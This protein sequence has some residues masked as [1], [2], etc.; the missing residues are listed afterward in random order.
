MN[1]HIIDPDKL[2]EI[3]E[4]KWRNYVV[5]EPLWTPVVGG[6]KEHTD[7]NS[8]IF[9]LPNG[10]SFSFHNHFE[11]NGLTIEDKNRGIIYFKN[12]T[13]VYYFKHQGVF[14]AESIGNG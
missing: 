7:S 9:D 13:G 12:I 10:V 11:P 2:E 6:A 8:I 5:T 14:V 1:R 3:W 4:I